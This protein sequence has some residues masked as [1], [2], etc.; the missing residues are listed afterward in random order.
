MENT[1]DLHTLA[2]YIGIARND[3]RTNLEAHTVAHTRSKRGSGASRAAVLLPTY[4]SKNQAIAW[5]VNL[6]TQ[7]DIQALASFL[8]TR[9]IWC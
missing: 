7:T 1:S 9:Y 3:I 2:R 6:V 5:C 4:N 8:Q